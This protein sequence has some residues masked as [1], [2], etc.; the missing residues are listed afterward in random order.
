[1]RRRVRVQRATPSAVGLVTER[2]RASGRPDPSAPPPTI[3]LT[4][5]DR[6]RRVAAPPASAGA[7]PG[8]RGSGRSRRSG[9][10]GD[11]DRVGRGERGDD[12]RRR[13]PSRAGEADL[14]DLGRLAKPDEVLLEL[15]P[16]VVGPDLASDRLVGHRQD[17]APRSRARAGA[18]ARPRSA[19]RPR[20]A[21][22]PRTMCVARSRSP[23]RNHVSSP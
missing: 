13:P 8:P 1:V 7:G 23:S 6:E 18:R 22:G 19:G 14:A 21:L 11:D 10:T 12:L 20:G 17:R 2:T 16:A 5:D 4:A 3:P 15:E 9:S